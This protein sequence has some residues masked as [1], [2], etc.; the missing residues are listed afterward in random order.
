M[1]AMEDAAADGDVMFA[2]VGDG[3]KLLQRVFPA[4][5]TAAEFCRS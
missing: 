4:P 2:K 3:L 5:A 1:H